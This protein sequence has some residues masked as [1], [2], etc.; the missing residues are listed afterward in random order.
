MS[1]P[2]NKK[3][4]FKAEYST[5]KELCKLECF[6]LLPNPYIWDEYV[7]YVIMICFYK[8]DEVI[9]RI[10]LT[11]YSGITYN[12]RRNWVLVKSRKLKKVIE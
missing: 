8:K 10:A 1:V 11:F 5:K 7:P 3:V 4:E 9:L 6:N 2:I 12:G